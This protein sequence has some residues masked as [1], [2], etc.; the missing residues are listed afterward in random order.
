MT[1]PA[2]TLV[3]R[4]VA[5]VSRRLFIQTLLSHLAVAWAAALAATAGW[6]LAEPF[7]LAEPQPQLRWIV[8][9]VALGLAT[10][11]A[12]VTALRRTPGRTRAAL[13]LD[14]QF[15]LRERVTT[16]YS[17]SPAE[18]ASPA[19]QALLA[20]VQ[21]RVEKLDVAGKFPI[22]LR[23][24]SALV[25]AAGVAVA[26]I[27]LFYNPTLPSAQGNA[28]KDR[29]V[30]QED[31]KDIDKKLAEFGKKQPREP[32]ALAEKPKSEELKRLEA[33]LEEIAKLPRE[34]TQQLRERVKDLTPLEEEIKKLE[35][36]RAERAKALQQQLSQKDKLM[37]NDVPNNGPAK[38]LQKAL[39]DGNLDQ[40]KEE[41]DKLAKKLQKN[42]LTQ[43]EK[44]QLN[45][46]LNELQKKMERLAEQKDKEE[47]LKQLA[48]EGK[49]DPEALQRELQELKKDTEKLK[50][51]N[52]LA[53]K[54][55]QCQ[56]ALKEGDSKSAGAALG[57]AAGELA[58]I[59]LDTKELDDLRDQMQKL[60]GAKDAMCKACDGD[61]Q[62]LGGE[63]EGDANGQSR[64]RKPGRSINGGG[65]AE[66]ASG[67]RPDGEQRKISTFDARANAQFNAKGKKVFDGYAPG[68]SFKKK[69]GVELAGEIQQAAQE[70]PEA[71]EVQR[72]PKAA[73]DMAKGYFKNLG[74]QGEGAPVKAPPAAEPEKK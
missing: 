20:D 54:L 52:K 22:R 7:A 53:Q 55:G 56:K 24:S 34:T 48:K 2:R 57:E 3:E 67:P 27:V 8:L 74:G 65:A 33:K 16:A 5:R 61:A 71:I 30:A 45:K 15:Q 44:E 1:L 26:L 28:G 62:M 32:L 60:Q 40:A 47:Q 63:N 69:P 29:P 58:Q 31:K 6:L 19:G 73:K 14:E 35:R 21:T 68:Q 18:L 38:D 4:Q 25:P 11:T 64:G 70:A 59:D 12:V 42:E 17:L 41:L 39:A 43:Q 50:D 46:Q 13:S 9:G 23:W 51:L 66:G 49:L 37:P 72:I 10:V 36:E